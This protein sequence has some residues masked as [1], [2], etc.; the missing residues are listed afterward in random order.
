[1]MARPTI[2]F[3]ADL[4]DLKKIVVAHENYDEMKR[5]LDEAR[6]QLAEPQ[7]TS[8]YDKARLAE[9]IKALLAKLEEAEK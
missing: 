3:E 6:C 8:H 9:K 4:S 1:M 7:Q 2:K 5:L